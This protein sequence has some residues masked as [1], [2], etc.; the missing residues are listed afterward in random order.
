MPACE[1][2]SASLLAMD[3]FPFAFDDRY[4]RILRVIGVTPHNSVV[5][6]D[7]EQL[8]VRF[9]RWRLGTPLSNITGMEMSGDYRWYKAIGARGSFAD[10]GL[11]FGTNVDRGLCVKFAEPVPALV[12]GDWLKHPGMTVTVADVDG[13]A[14]ALQSRGVPI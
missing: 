7:D 2:R 8:S 3:R 12:I 13:L 9:G 4:R 5:T 14:E 10:R 6:V 11:T 1:T